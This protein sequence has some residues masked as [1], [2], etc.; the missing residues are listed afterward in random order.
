[1]GDW[2]LGPLKD[3]ALLVV[4]E[5]V[6]NAVK[7]RDVF[8]FV[9]DRDGERALVEV[10]DAGPGKPAV[11][12]AGETDIGGRGLLLVEAISDDWGV[13]F[14]TGGGKTVWAVIS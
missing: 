9:L 6:T 5:L 2:G 11:K 1:M 3:N 13:R 4:S 7:Q 8:Q 14:E 10:T 12:N